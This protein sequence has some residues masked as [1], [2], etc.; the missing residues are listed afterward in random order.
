MRKK[1]TTADVY[2][3]CDMYKGGHTIV[4]CAKAVGCTYRTA[5]VWLTDFGLRKSGKSG[6]PVKF[7]EDVV[8]KAVKL[9]KDGKSAQECAEEIGCRVNAIYEWLRKRQVPVH[10]KLFSKDTRKAAIE[11]RRNGAKLREVAEKYGISMGYV[12]KLCK[13]CEKGKSAED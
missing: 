4:D 2:K 10:K 5:M 13:S 9:Y 3:V 8:D 12:N 7:G 11:M 1:Y 6:R